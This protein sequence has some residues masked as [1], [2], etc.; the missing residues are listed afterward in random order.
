[1]AE[2]RPLRAD[3]RRNR[4]RVLEV[5]AEVFAAEG[6]SVP[7]HEIARRAGVGTGTVS[8]HFPAKEDLFAAILLTRME[9][10]SVRADSLAQEDPATAFFTFF[11]ALIHE[12]ASNRGLAEAVAGAGYDLDVLG[13]RAGFDVSG[14]VR[15]LL[16]RAQRA[17]AVR[18]DV[19]YLD[20]KALM[21]ACMARATPAAIAVVC[22]GL[23]A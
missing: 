2:E 10:L 12:G 14:R 15:A 18:S 23:R 19:D 8:R 20:V 16:A 6:L 1:M 5:A 13:E 3:A 9:E 7:V 22:D 21:T 17:G 11:T 4:T